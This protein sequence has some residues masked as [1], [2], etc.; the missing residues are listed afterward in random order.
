MHAAGASV[1]AG[2]R[3]SAVLGQGGMEPCTPPSIPDCPGWWRSKCSTCRSPPTRSSGSVFSREGQLAASLE[4][5]HRAHLRLRRGSGPALA[6][7]A[8]GPRHYRCRAGGRSHLRACRSGCPGHPSR[9]GVRARFRAPARVVHRDVKPANILIDTETVRSCCRTSG[10]PGRSAATT[11]SPR[12]EA[13][14]APSTTARPNRSPAMISTAAATSTPGVHGHTAAHRCKAVH[15]ADRGIG[16]QTSPRRSRPRWRRCVRA[17]ADSRRRV[18]G[19]WPEARGSLYLV[20]GVR[21]RAGGF[22]ARRLPSGFTADAP[23][24]PIGQRPPP[25]LHFVVLRIRGEAEDFTYT[26][27][28][29]THTVTVRRIARPA[30]CPS[31]GS[32]R[33]EGGSSHRQTS[34]IRRGSATR[35]GVVGSARV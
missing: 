24:R 14:S 7:H 10:S 32:P 22:A 2:H 17:A 8:P 19:L 26:I 27:A 35:R 28:E 4:H 9:G 12:P 15:Q 34:L 25:D 6:E 23:T 30:T 13:S 31:I 21:R 33:A 5:P 29:I 11:D 3:V 1:I 18:P 20:R 16:D